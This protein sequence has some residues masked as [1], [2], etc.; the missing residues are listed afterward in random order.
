MNSDIAAQV[1]P[2]MTN[3]AASSAD[4]Y[5]V[6][7]ISGAQDLPFF[8]DHLARYS[9][10]MQWTP[11][12]R[13]LDIC[14]GV[15]YGTFI[16]ASAGASSVLGL[17]IAGEA[18]S[19]ARSQPPLPN[20]AFS[21]QDACLPYPNPGSWDLVTCF[22]GVEHV[23]DPKKLLANIHGALQSGGV[24]VVSSPNSDGYAKGH[25]GNPFHPSEMKEAEFRS[26]VDALPWSVE[27]YA[28]IAKEA[29]WRRP[30][31]QQALIR[32]LPAAVRQALQRS[33]SSGSAESPEGLWRRGT[34]GG[35]AR[36]INLL[37]T[38][39]WYPRPWDEAV[40]VMYQ[41]PPHIILA[42]CRRGLKP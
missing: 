30:R 31:W 27:W 13:V 22:E 10:A 23:P 36:D 40:K 26:L 25:S 16:L 1:G 38:D 32:S 5:Y 35:K 11:G 20:L 12:R 2:A 18:I 33:K 39:D 3:P 41:P 19:A 29:V 28:Q 6:E 4:S 8:P 24:A 17:D 9:F 7:R 42:V 37:A 21:V 34:D 14:C 15:G